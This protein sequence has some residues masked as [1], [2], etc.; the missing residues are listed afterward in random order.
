MLVLS[1]WDAPIPLTRAWCLWEILCTIIN[2]ADFTV[3]LSRAQNT[4]FIETLRSDFEYIST[5]LCRIDV[6]KSQ[7]WK[8]E[9]LSN[10]TSRHTHPL[11][12]HKA[13]QHA[14]SFIILT[15]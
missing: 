4:S 7:A 6:E 3:Q 13:S 8:S 1:P 15:L 14:Q 9:G 5:A 10:I 12:I 11:F 2:K